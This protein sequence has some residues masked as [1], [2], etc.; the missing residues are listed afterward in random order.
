MT[1]FY[2]LPDQQQTTNNIVRVDGCGA[3]AQPGRSPNS[4]TPDG[5]CWP[6]VSNITAHTRMFTSLRSRDMRDNQNK[7]GWRLDD[8]LFPMCLVGSPLRLPHQATDIS[9]PYVSHTWYLS[10]G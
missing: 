1:M 3:D 5:S 6:R 7:A 10:L 2:L 4:M 8:A 9:Q